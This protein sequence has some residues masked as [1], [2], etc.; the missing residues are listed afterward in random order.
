MVGTPDGGRAA[1]NLRDVVDFDE[2]TSIPFLFTR[3]PIYPDVH[4]HMNT[5]YADAFLDVDDLF[6]V[7]D[8]AAKTTF[9]ADPV[10]IV[11]DRI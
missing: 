7:E 11:K 10:A 8:P 3:H 2:I 6:T 1:P 4:S 9:V 5:I